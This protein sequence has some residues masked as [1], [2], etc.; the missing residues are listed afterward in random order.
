ME[1][2]KEI[3]MTYSGIV[4]QKG[5]K[6]VRVIFERGKS[7][8][9][10]CIVPTGM[11]EKSSGFTK[12][13]LAQLTVYLKQNSADILQRAKEVNPIRSWIHKK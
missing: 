5:Q 6:I 13:E 7:D 10:E 8:F 9:A 11:I 12:E 3:R 2:S 4:M 1:Y